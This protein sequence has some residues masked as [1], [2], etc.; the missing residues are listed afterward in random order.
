MDGVLLGS[1]ELLRTA[2]SREPGLKL[3]LALGDANLSERRSSL[4]FS[5]ACR[6]TESPVPLEATCSRTRTHVIEIGEASPL[7]SIFNMHQLVYKDQHCLRVNQT[8]SSSFDDAVYTEPTT[9][10]CG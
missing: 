7:R 4:S 9:T 8:G 1:M 3:P 2:S 5:L 6:H 10:V